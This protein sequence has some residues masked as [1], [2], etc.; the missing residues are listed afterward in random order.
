MN[1]A[2]KLY[3]YTP[4]SVLK[5]DTR[6]I[7]AKVSPFVSWL[8]DEIFGHMLKCNFASIRVKNLR[9]YQLRN[10]KRANIFYAP[11]QC[12]WDGMIGYYLSRKVF[13]TDIRI[14]VEDLRSFPILS[15]IGCFSVSKNNP[16]VSLK[17]LNYVISFLKNSNGLGSLWIFPQGVIN[18][19]DFR[20]IEFAQ[21]IS[22][23]SQ[24]LDGVNLFPISMRYEFLRCE[25]PEV[26]IELGKPILLKSPIEDRKVFNSFLQTNFEINLDRQKIEICSGNLDN[27]IKI[28]ERREPLLRKI[29]KKLKS[30]G[31]NRA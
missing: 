27:Y 23:I 31:L 20:P 7:P 9:Y 10:K 11:H 24:K 19:P 18:P 15:R 30:Y 12:W 3:N 1:Q 5:N 17:S 29:E 13:K 4:P 8:F 2:E 21:G 6:F 26:L 25:K 22:Y 28:L 14:M 16:S